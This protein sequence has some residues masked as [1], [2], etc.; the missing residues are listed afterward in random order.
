MAFALTALKKIQISG[1]ESTAGS[2]AAAT[3]IITD[4]VMDVDYGDKVL[5]HIEQD[6]NLMSKNIAG[7]SIIVGKEVS[8][9]IEMAMNLQNVLYAITSTVRGNITPTQPDA[10]NEPLAF[11]WTILPTLTAGNTPDITDGIDTFTLEY[12]DNE[13]DYESEFAYGTTVTI[14]GD[15]AGESPVMVTWEWTARQITETTLTPALTRTATK[16]FPAALVK[17]YIDANYAA[18]GGTEVPAMLRTWEITINSEMTPRQGAGGTLTFD[19]LDEAEKTVELE[20]TYNRG[21]NSELEKDKYDTQVQSYI[22]IECNGADEIDSGQS[23]PPYFRFDASIQYTDAP[24]NDDESGTVVETFT[25]E[26][27]YD[28]TASKEYGITMLTTLAAY[29]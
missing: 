11:L 26:T 13:Q 2:A 18:I 16:E 28:P 4:G 12:G 14:S 6:K 8:G 23:N 19:G 21:T 17:F 24:S 25:A 20:L 22:R 15:G 7:D 3:A 1:V 10:T 9:S 29:P 27:F 5:H